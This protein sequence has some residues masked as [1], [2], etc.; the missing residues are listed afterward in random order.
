MPGTLNAD[1]AWKGMTRSPFAKETP[2]P[3][4]AAAKSGKAYCA[5]LLRD[6][7]HED[8]T[9]QKRSPEN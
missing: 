3:R 2:G 9:A 4:P 5:I 8:A 6:A 7:S 1:L